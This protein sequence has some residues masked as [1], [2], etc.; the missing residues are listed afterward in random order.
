MTRPPAFV[1]NSRPAG[2]RPARATRHSGAGTGRLLFD[3]MSFLPP[4][5]RL[6]VGGQARVAVRIT[7]DRRAA[8]R[9]VP[10]LF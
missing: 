7:S 10:R 5:V 4:T 9:A 6:L 2:L 3:T 1:H 8:L